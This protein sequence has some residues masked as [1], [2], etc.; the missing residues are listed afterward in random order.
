VRSSSLS[1]TDFAQQ[2]A[3]ICRDGQQQVYHAVATVL[4]GDVYPS[5]FPSAEFASFYQKTAQIGANAV[6]RLRQLPIPS[7]QQAQMTSDLASLTSTVKWARAV[8]RAAAR[9]DETTYRELVNAPA[10]GL[11]TPSLLPAECL[12]LSLGPVVGE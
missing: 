11:T 6:A 4:H 1:A 9:R 3:R 10:P 12:E 5:S 7:G 8:G 2:A